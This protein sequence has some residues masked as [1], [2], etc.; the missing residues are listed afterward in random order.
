M[1]AHA[2]LAAL[3]A[4]T[5]S[6][7]AKGAAETEQPSSPSPWQRS[8]DSWTLSCPTHEPTAIPH[9]HTEVVGLAK[10]SPGHRP[11]LPL[12][13]T[14]LRTRTAAGLLAV[15]AAAAPWADRG[16][17]HLVRFSAEVVSGY[18]LERCRACEQAVRQRAIAGGRP[19]HPAARHPEMGRAGRAPA[20]RIMT[21]A[22]RAAD[23]SGQ[24][25]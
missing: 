10:T 14:Q 7:T 9:P 19:L 3:T 2:V 20:G 8:G 25:G 21:V 13:K 18:R 5:T 12:P 17:D 11:P 1:L 15:G 6:D 24:S 4:Q 23:G 22:R 16:I